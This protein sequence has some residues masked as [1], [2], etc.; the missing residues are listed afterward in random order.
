[1]VCFATAA[2]VR[3]VVIGGEVLMEGRQ[4]SHLNEAEIIAAAEAETAQMLRRSGLAHLAV[5]EPGWGR[6]RYVRG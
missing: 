4:L 3:D 6:T 5:E 1:V 2:D